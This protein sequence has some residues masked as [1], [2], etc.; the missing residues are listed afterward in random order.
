[1]HASLFAM[2]LAELLVNDTITASCQTNKSPKLY[3]TYNLFQALRQWGRR[4]VRFLS[5]PGT[6]Y[7]TC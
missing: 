6:F 2:E 7:S 3:S 5:Q 4:G 1:M